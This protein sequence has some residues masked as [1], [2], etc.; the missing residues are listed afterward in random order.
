MSIHFPASSHRRRRTEGAPAWQTGRFR[1]ERAMRAARPGGH[2]APDRACGK[3]V[4]TAKL[5]IAK[6]E[7]GPPAAQSRASFRPAL[8]RKGRRTGP[9]R[10]ALRSGARR[11]PAHRAAS[12]AAPALRHAAALRGG[13]RKRTRGLSRGGSSAC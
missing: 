7:R 11:L 9:R 12:R 4:E 10:S 5:R 6:G 2:R 8:W 3:C 1:P 13:G